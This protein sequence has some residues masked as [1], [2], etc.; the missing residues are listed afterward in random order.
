MFIQS[1]STSVSISLT[2]THTYI[3]IEIKQK[4]FLGHFLSI[5]SSISFSTFILILNH[6]TSFDIFRSSTHTQ[7]WARKTFSTLRSKIPFK[8][9]ARMI[10]EMEISSSLLV[11]WMKRWRWNHN[12]YKKRDFLLTYDWVEPSAKIPLMTR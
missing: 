2:T 6:F 5:L 12:N 8:A 1:T 3:L 10:I 7:S 11:E 4:Q 9:D